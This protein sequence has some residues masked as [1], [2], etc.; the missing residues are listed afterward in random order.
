MADKVEN[1]KISKIAFR[2]SR[3]KRW[4]W[5]AVRFFFRFFFMILFRFR[6]IGR[7]NY[8]V[9]GGGLVC[10][11]HQSHFDP[12]I[13]GITCNRRLN[14]L[15]RRTLYESK[16]LSPLMEFLDGIPLDRDGSGIGG[17]KEMIRRLKRGELVAL[18]PE[19]TRTSDGEV[20]KLK[21]GFTM[22]ARRCKSVI[23]PVGM[24]G[25]YQVWPKGKAIPGFGRIAVSVGKP[26]PF[27]EYKDLTDDALVLL[28]AERIRQCHLE[29]K[30]LI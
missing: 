20:A 16:I 17:L 10:S 15:A 4:G 23:I 28:V 13:V 27:S 6:S 19:G 22:V 9:E 2:R 29:A 30:K 7:T 25:A 24:D 3:F 11:N 12:L 5:S 8:P 21:S 18:F 1:K 14:F 26:I